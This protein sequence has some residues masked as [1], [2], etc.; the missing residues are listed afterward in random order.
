MNKASALVYFAAFSGLLAGC[1]RTKEPENQ[2]RADSA[3]AASSQPQASPTAEPGK[4]TNPPVQGQVD[5]KEPA[6]RRD[7]ETPKR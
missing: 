1:D 7:F 2:T 5:T 3:P 6:Q 4:N